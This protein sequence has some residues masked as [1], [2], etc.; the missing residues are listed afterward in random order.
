AGQAARRALEAARRNVAALI[1]AS[2]SDEIVFTSGGS[3]SNVTA[4]R[5]ALAGRPGRRAVVTSTVE[6]ASVHATLD[7]LAATD[8]IAVRRVP[9]G[10]DGRLALRAYQAALGP[11]TALV[12]LMTANNETGTLF[13]IADLV[14]AAHAAGAL[15]HTDAVQAAGRVDIDMTGRGVDLVS[16]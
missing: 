1:G 6:H 11:D 5:S 4:I 2:C 10:G 14:P 13:P 15:F 16:L 8:G 3:E 7:R 9:V 12:T